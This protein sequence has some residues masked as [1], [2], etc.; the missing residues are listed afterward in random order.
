MLFR[1]IYS[2]TY[3]IYFFFLSKSFIRNGQKKK[4]V[5]VVHSKVDSV[6][7][8]SICNN[9]FVEKRKLTSSYYLTVSSIMTNEITQ[10]NVCVFF[11]F[12]HFFPQNFVN[13]DINIDRSNLTRKSK[14]ICRI[15]LKIPIKEGKI[16]SI[17]KIKNKCHYNEVSTA[18]I[19]PRC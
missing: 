9:I 12:S 6:F 8:C 17:D 11:L 1:D 15:N 3:F 13:L 16:Q 14:S 19:Y 5:R 2:S 10:K 4:F 7:F 18:S